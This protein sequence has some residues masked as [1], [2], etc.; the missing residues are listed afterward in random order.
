MFDCSNALIL[1]MSNDHSVLTG[2]SE[3]PT[4]SVAVLQSYFPNR[5]ELLEGNSTTVL[6]QLCR[7]CYSS[8]SP[9][10]DLLHINATHDYSSVLDDID[11][12]QHVAT[13]DAIVVLNNIDAEGVERAVTQSRLIYLRKSTYRYPPLQRPSLTIVTML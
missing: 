3:N 1:L 9:R 5:I 2:I 13:D 8:G 4:K 6:S 11:I 12:C 7:R 10:Y